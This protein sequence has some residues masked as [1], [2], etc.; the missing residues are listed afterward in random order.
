MTCTELQ[1][2]E[3]LDETGSVLNYTPL[4]NRHRLCKA[5]SPILSLHSLIYCFIF[6]KNS[7]NTP[8]KSVGLS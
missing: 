4:K 1:S 5:V 3:Y 6:D 7:F 2:D 8:L